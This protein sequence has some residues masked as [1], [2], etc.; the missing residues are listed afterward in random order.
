M[1]DLTEDGLPLNS[2]LYLFPTDEAL[3]P[4]KQWAEEHGLSSSAAA[5]PSISTG[6]L[7]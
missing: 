3:V 7:R 5:A 2:P 1:G 4:L 6:A